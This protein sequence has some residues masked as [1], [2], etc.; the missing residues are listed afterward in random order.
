NQIMAAENHR[1]PQIGA[2][3]MA[4][5]ERLEVF[6]AQVAV[7]GLQLFAVVARPAGNIE[8][9]FIHIRRIDLDSAAKFLSPQGLGKHHRGGIGLLARST[10]GAPYPDRI[11]RRFLLKE[12]GN[13]L[14]AQVTPR[15][16]IAK[17]R[18]DIDQDRIE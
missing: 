1:T 10:A 12:P 14:L 3:D 4:A 13:D 8:G 17:E 2:K 6:A 5:I 9:L 18:R 7:P 16:G 11:S 15:H